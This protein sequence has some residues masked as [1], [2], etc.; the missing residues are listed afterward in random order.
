MLSKLL[1]IF[2]YFH[3]LRSDA[4]GNTEHTS[5]YACNENGGREERTDV[6]YGEHLVRRI[7]SPQSFP[8]TTREAVDFS[9][10][11]FLFSS[12]PHIRLATAVPYLPGI[13]KHLACVRTT[14]TYLTRRGLVVSKCLFSYLSRPSYITPNFCPKNLIFFSPHSLNF[15]KVNLHAQNALLIFI[16]PKKRNNKLRK[17]KKK[18]NNREKRACLH[19]PPRGRHE[20][21]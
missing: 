8:R 1:N 13:S 12:S 16:T 14:L 20:R 10:L 11:T 6:A 9:L 18:K 17:I 19:V 5:S 7:L 4:A 15:D 21:M 3:I 2:K